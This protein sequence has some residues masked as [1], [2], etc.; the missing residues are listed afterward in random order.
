MTPQRNRL[1]FIGAG[2]MGQ[3]IIRGL[4]SQGSWPKDAITA[5]DANRQGLEALRDELGIHVASS[6]LEAV[7][8]ADAV[9]VAVKP[10][11]VSS[12]LREMS[13]SRAQPLVISI[14]AGLQTQSIE[15]LMPEQTRVIRVMPNLPMT[16]GCGACT[17][18][19]GAHA[20]D[21]DMALAERV[22]AC[23]G[24]THVLPEKLLDAA[25]AVAGSGPAYVFLF[26]EAL[27]EA[28]VKAGLP[29][30]VARDLAAQTVLG[31]AKMCSEGTLSAGELRELVTSPGGTTAAALAALER[32]ALRSVV[33]SAVDAAVEK[34]AQLAKLD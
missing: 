6:N 13:S 29:R 27:I 11:V 1:S 28:G 30:N 2:N 31:A 5:T 14:V 33:M 21:E 9:I 10:Q 25:T 4:L 20:R 19:R 17:L 15:E 26:T 7:D 18:C 22:F 3:A 34:A 16:V 24:T 12:V 23:V 32:G 8:G